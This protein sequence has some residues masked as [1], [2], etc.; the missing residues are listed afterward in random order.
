MQSRRDQVQAHLFVMSRLASGMLRA[1]PDTPDTPTGRTTRGAV[2]G[3]AVGL[4]IGLVVA[5]YGVMKPGGSTGWEKPGAL[6]MVE[7][8]GA[9]YLYLGGT[10]HPVLNQAS[11]KLLAGDRMT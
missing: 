8:T 9:R 2:V 11:A 10:L 7:E 1:E 3:L 4:V 6:V 5:V